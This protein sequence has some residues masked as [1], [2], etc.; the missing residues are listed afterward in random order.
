M[1]GGYVV[2]AL[3]GLWALLGLIAFV[4]SILCF[5]STSSIAEKIIGLV[6]AVL[7]GPF[8]FLYYYL[9]PRY[10]KSYSSQNTNTRR[11]NAPNTKRNASN[12]KRN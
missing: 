11:N 8:Y 1:M 4:K 5:S 9:N 2:L 7:F 12:N 6:L 3:G 10:C